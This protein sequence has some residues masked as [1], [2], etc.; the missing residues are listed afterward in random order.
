[1]GGGGERFAVV[2]SWRTPDGPRTRWAQDLTLRDGKIVGMRDYAQPPRALR[3]ALILTV[4]TV[5]ISALVWMLRKS[6]NPES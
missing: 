1:M 4:V 6:K 5:S 2:Y 3:P